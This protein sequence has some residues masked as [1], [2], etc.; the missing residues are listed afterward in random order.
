MLADLQFKIEE[1]DAVITRDPL[2]T[3][4]GDERQLR[5]LFQNL[6]T[7]AIEYSGDGPPRIH[8]TAEERAEN[9]T[10]RISVRDDGLGI[11]PAEADRIFDIFHRL[12]SVDDHAGSG[13]GLALCERIVERHGGDIRAESEPGEGSTVSFTLAPDRDRPESID[14]IELPDR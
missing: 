13:I 7:N 12:H 10:W 14:G 4:D 2:P 9:E 11:D 6:L 3:V 1:T 8:V 5:Q